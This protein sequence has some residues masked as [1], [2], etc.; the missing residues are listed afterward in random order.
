MSQKDEKTRKNPYEDHPLN[1][2]KVQNA[3]FRDLKKGHTINMAA[4]RNGV[5][6][7]ALYSYIDNHPAFA[8]KLYKAKTDMQE[9][10]FERMRNLSERDHPSAVR[11]TEILMER[12]DFDP[13]ADTTNDIQGAVRVLADILDARNGS[14]TNA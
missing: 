13:H 5:K 4:R 11:A 14:E 9:K 10:F 6:P 1:S 3:I 2:T 8:G 12:A 7:K